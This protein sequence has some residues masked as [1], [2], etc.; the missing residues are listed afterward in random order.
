LSILFETSASMLHY[1]NRVSESLKFDLGC[2]DQ[3]DTVDLH[4]A[5]Q[6]GF[7]LPGRG[8]SELVS[9]LGHSAGQ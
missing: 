6:Q 9:S 3:V 5:V 1:C 2:H 8:A 4:T 7:G